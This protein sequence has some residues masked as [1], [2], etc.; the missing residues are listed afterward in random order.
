MREAGCCAIPISCASGSPL[1]GVPCLC[2]CPRS[3]ADRA[4]SSG[5]AI[6][7]QRW[8]GYW[9]GSSAQKAE[10]Y[11]FTHKLVILH[12]HNIGSGSGS[13]S[14]N[15]VVDGSAFKY[16]SAVCWFF[17]HAGHQVVSSQAIEHSVFKPPAAAGTL[18]LNASS[19]DPACPPQAGKV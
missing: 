7:A 18:H 3:S 8:R 9:F 4:S 6:A 11:R 14:A 5:S 10:L 17:G 15:A 1:V 12:L 19:P 2:A 13:W 16:F